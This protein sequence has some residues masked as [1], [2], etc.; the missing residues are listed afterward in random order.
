MDGE[1]KSCRSSSSSSRC[2]QD[3][4]LK[5]ELHGRA[6]ST[7]DR[8]TTVS[9]LV[10]GRVALVLVLI[11]TGDPCN[12]DGCWGV[13]CAEGC[14]VDGCLPVVAIYQDALVFALGHNACTMIPVTSD[15]DRS[16]V[17]PIA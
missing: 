7:S 8:A 17:V 9:P 11:P 14:G 1:R 3:R 4:W 16:H 15:T 5:F 13:T 12:V 6:P 2:I 10:H